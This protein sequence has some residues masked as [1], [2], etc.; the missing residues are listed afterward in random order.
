ME[1]GE[2]KMLRKSR[3]GFTL[4]ELMIVVAII[5]ILAA[6]AIPKFA[7]LIRKSKEGATKG[8]IGS[9]RSAL[10]I[11]YG[12]NE[13][14]YPVYLYNLVDTDSTAESTANG[15]TDKKYL[16]EIPYA[17]IGGYQHSDRNTV[18]ADATDDEDLDIPAD[19]TYGWVYGSRGTANA[20]DDGKLC[21][22][23]THTDTKN[24]QISTW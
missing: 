3:K 8:N 22:A 10:S 14:T 16:D 18:V 5:G 7:D 23:C 20:A 11:Y 17:K 2:I 24:N 4:I 1:G 12:E 19:W 13:G 9:V 15:S 6:I 21:V